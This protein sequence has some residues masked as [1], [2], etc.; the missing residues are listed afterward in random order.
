VETLRDEDLDYARRI[1]VAGGS[2]ELHVWPGAFHAFDLIA[3]GSVLART[4]AEVRLAWLRRIT[5][6]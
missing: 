5:A 3:P 4:A 6:C 2:A 1:W